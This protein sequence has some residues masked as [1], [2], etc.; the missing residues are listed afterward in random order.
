MTALRDSTRLVDHALPP[1]GRVSIRL[2]SAEVHITA[3]AGDRVT[4]GTPDGVEP[5]DRL[6]VESTG[7]E[8]AIRERDVIGLAFGKLHKSLRLDV[9][10]PS[11]ADTT[12]D[13]ASGRIRA[14]GLRGRQRYRT[15]SGDVD[16]TNAGGPIEV[17]AVSGDVA[18]A[19]AE[20]ASLSVRTV[21]GDVTAVGGS[22]ASLRISTT[23]G[24][25]RVDSPITGATGNAIETLSGDATIVATAGISV[26]ARTVSGDLSSDLPHRS[27]G[28]TGRRT[29]VIGDGRVEL[30]FRSVSGDLRIRGQATD[31]TA[32]TA[33]SPPA[34]AVAPRPPDAAS[35]APGQPVPPRPSMPVEHRG[36]TGSGSPASGPRDVDD[37]RMAILRALER[38]ELDIATSMDRLAE[39]DDLEIRDLP[40]A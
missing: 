19:L 3:V 16:V 10:V 11:A 1:G 29:L 28:R 21:S 26:V 5:G 7:G 38:G 34:A 22:L 33:P 2:A 12:V 23:S 40:D 37:E 36:S 8:L 30:S 24:D 32:P 27:D 18:I 4:I 17:D 13:V 15:A 20:A 6:T 9:D 35:P 39:L 25:V 14:R 31:P